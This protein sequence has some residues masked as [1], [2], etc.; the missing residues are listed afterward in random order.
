[1]NPED[2]YYNKLAKLTETVS[3]LI[4]VPLGT[5]GNLATLIIYNQKP[6]VKLSFSFYISC[7][8][9]I[10]TLI[11]YI[12]SIPRIL[13]HYY[14]IEI[15]IYPI[16][17]CK[18]LF[19][20]VYTLHQLSSWLVVLGSVE[21]LAIVKFYHTWYS[22]FESRRFQFLSVSLITLIL[23]AINSPNLVY[24]SVFEFNSSTEP[25]RTLEACLLE[26]GLT[27]LYSYS[28]RSII[29]LLVYLIF[30][31]VLMIMC[32]ILISRNILETKKITGVESKF[33]RQRYQ[34][35][36]T[37]LASN[38]VFFVLNL[39]IC[40]VMIIR[41]LT[42]YDDFEKLNLA[43][44]LGSM[45]AHLNF[46]TSVFVHLSIN[47]LFARRFRKIF[48]SNDPRPVSYNHRSLLDVELPVLTGTRV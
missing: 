18:I 13:A 12:S 31:F 1:M 44:A 6:L 43:Y 11:L 39:P 36:L 38:I 47:R 22:W 28:L 2:N 30:P 37:L 24:L 29:D 3:P 41:S 46:A 19:T 35:S 40:L 42:D 17:G 32:S 34:L 48:L 23:L 4:L 10:N 26:N 45:C 20:S 8:V 14:N 15:T 27:G 9:I 25:N 5:I 33:L 7:L 16:A 21:R